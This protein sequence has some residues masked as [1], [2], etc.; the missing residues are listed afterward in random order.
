M[1][2]QGGLLA[3]TGSRA[4]G[5]V[6]LRRATARQSVFRQAGAVEPSIPVEPGPLSVPGAPPQPLSF[7]NSRILSVGVW[8]LASSLPFLEPDAGWDGAVGP[9][10]NLGLSKDARSRT[11]CP[12]CREERWGPEIGARLKALR[13]GSGEG[14]SCVPFARAFL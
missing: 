5:E 13:S 11:P 9:R 2:G 14:A 10:G 12:S 7:P 6:G 3:P 1:G 8:P 4:P